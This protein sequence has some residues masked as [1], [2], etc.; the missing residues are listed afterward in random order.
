MGTLSQSGEKKSPV[1]EKE[2]RGTSAPAR[3]TPIEKSIFNE[4]VP[5]PPFALSHVMMADDDALT[6]VTSTD[7][8][9]GAGCSKSPVLVGAPELDELDAVA[10]D[11]LDA[12]ALDVALDEPPVPEPEDAVALTLLLVAVALGAPPCPPALDDDALV[13]VAAPPAPPELDPTLLPAHALVHAAATIIP[14]ARR[15]VSSKPSSSRGPR[16]EQARDAK[17]SDATRSTP[18]HRMRARCDGACAARL[19]ASARPQSRATSTCSSAVAENP[20]C[21]DG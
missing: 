6:G 18:F 16:D 19:H 13:V 14:I 2:T 11:E 12:D 21:A 10:L 9:H 5:Q 1:G 4:P 3:C 8:V 20:F 15:I 17:G 7:C